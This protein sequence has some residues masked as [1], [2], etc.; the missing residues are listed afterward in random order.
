MNFARFK[1][2]HFNFIIFSPRNDVS[3][4][5]MTQKLILIQIFVHILRPNDKRYIRI[6]NI[7]IGKI[8]GEF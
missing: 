5:K 6:S 2:P 7:L 1:I 8:S 4:F 3:F